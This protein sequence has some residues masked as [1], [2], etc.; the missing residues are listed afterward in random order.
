MNHTALALVFLTGLPLLGQTQPK[1]EVTSTTVV[2]V[3]EHGAAKSVIAAAYFNKLAAAQGLPY[4]AVARGTKPDPEVSATVRTDLTSR[5][6]SVPSNKPQAVTDDEIQ[7]A[8]KVVSM[9]TD[10]P[11]TKPAASPKLV[12]WNSI[13][14]VGEEYDA[15]RKSIAEQVE[16]LVKSLTPQKKN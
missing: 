7:R 1:P 3:C 6:L 15:A 4:T 9:A 13:P 16:K 14:S 10:L 8:A 11:A 12:E 5:G 2:F